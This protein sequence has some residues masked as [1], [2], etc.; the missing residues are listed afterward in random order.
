[1]D[2]NYN[3]GNYGGQ[4]AYG[5]NSQSQYEQ[6]MR[7]EQNAQ[8]GQ[9]AYGQGEQAGY[10]QNAYSYGQSAQ[11]GYQQNTYS[12]SAYASYNPYQQVASKPKKKKSGFGTK[13]AKCAAIALVFGLVSGAV[14]TG[15][16]YAGSRALGMSAVVDSDRDSGSN[17][18]ISNSNTVQQTGVGMATDLTDVSAIFDEVIPSIVAITN[19]GTVTYRTFWGTQKYQSESRGS[20][21]IIG[22]N[23]KYLYIVTNNHVVQN[24]D[25]LT[26]QF[27]DDTTVSCEIQGTDPADDLAVV[28]VELNSIESGTHSKIKVAAVGDSEQLKVGN[29][30]IAIGNALG[31][32]QSLFCG[33]ISALGRTVTVQDETTGQTIVNNNMI[34]TS[35]AI[36]PGNSGGALL[37]ARGEV[38]GINSAKYSD[39]DVEGVGYAIPISDALPIVKQLIE[40]GKVEEPDSAYLGIQGQD[41]SENVAQAYD[42]PEGVY[43]Y[44]VLSGS[45][46]EKAGISTRDI[47]TALDGEK[48]MTMNELKALLKNYEPGQVAV[49]TLQR[50]GGDRRGYVEMEISVTL[51]SLKGSQQ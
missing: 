30:A 11:N 7:Y 13:L 6:N 41:I 1:M 4:G 22:Q 47:I 39:T 5:Q 15:V 21:I 49:V 51:G 33:H 38:I 9:S 12:Q 50:L 18:M 35:A 28:K 25:T 20:G 44:Q 19:T 29:P 34:Q 32:G 8:S 2:N 43:V 40:N 23:D 42:M 36:N 16:N 27:F 37:N 14:F 31:H 24:S 26:V 10:G 17:Y 48:V 46:A 3:T 45:A